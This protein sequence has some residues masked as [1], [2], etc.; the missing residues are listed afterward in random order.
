MHPSSAGLIAFGD[1][2]EGLVR[3]RWMAKHLSKCEKCRGELRRIRTEKEQLSLGTTAVAPEDLQPGLAALLSSMAAWRES[4]TV[5]LAS[6]VKRR[7]RSQIE[8]YLGAPA[9]SLVEWPGMRAEEL[10]ANAGE[11]LAA[12]LGPK[13]AEA[14]RDDVLGGLDCAGA[15][16]ET[17]R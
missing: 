5:V 10:F 6:E 14:L 7:V 17:H 3:R 11:I 2:E 8:M 15:A 1:R 13:A 9:V 4:R 12:L 16:A